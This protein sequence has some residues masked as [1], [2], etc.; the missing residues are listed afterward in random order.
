MPELNPTVTLQQFDDFLVA[1]GLVFEAVVIGGAAL[2]GLGI[3]TRTTDDVDVLGAASARGDRGGGRALC[4]AAAH[5]A[6]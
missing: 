1:E 6:E 3:V 2:H 5:T 4:R